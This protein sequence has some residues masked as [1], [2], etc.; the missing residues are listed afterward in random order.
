MS[1]RTSKVPDKRSWWHRLSSKDGKHVQDLHASMAFKCQEDP[2]VKQS[3]N[4]AI[5]LVNRFAS[6][7]HSFCNVNLHLV[8]L[9][10]I[11]VI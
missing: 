10:G 9:L 6:E 3:L 7:M 5:N 4:R 2:L 1:C 8:R 11:F